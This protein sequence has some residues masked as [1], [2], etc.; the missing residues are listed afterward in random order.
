MIAISISPRRDGTFA[1]AF[2]EAARAHQPMNAAGG[3]MLV[4]DWQPLPLEL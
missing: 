3:G 2:L 4:A 1:P